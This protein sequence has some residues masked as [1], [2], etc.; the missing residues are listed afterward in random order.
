[1][2]Q[3][4]NPRHAPEALERKL[5]PSGMIIPITAEYAPVVANVTPTESVSTTTPTTESAASTAQA[6]PARL[7]SN[8]FA[9]ATTQAGSA[10]KTSSFDPPPVPDPT[11]PSDPD[12][13]PTPV[14]G[15]AVPNGPSDPA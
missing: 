3:F 14:G 7:T 2:R 6:T 9:I 10:S 8:M 11:V 12:P 4:R 5:H 15:P 1:M 13:D